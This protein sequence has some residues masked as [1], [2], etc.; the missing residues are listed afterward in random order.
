M[1][2]KDKSRMGVA[3]SHGLGAWIDSRKKEK[4]RK[5]KR[6]RARVSIQLLRDVIK[7]FLLLLPWA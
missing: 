7:E 5:K 4:E 6:K 2:G 1:K 3:S